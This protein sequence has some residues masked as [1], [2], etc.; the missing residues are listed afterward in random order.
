MGLR[1]WPLTLIHVALRQCGWS[2][3]TRGMLP[4][5]FFNISWNYNY[6][7]GMARTHDTVIIPSF[8]EIC[9]GVSEP[10]VVEICPFLYFGY[11]LLQQIVLPSAYTGYEP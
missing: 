9:S 4:V 1:V 3:H 2:G 10:Q 7:V 5:R 11:W 6:V 8:I